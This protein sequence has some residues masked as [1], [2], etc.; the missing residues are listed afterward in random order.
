M[1]TLQRANLPVFAV[2][3]AATIVLLFPVYWMA[4]T[5]VLP[6]SIVLSREPPL[7]PPIDRMTLSAYAEVLGRRPVFQWMLNSLMVAAGSVAI[8]LVASTLAGYS[9][10]RNRSRAQE[11]VGLV[12]LLTKMLPGS[13]I[14]IPFFIMFTTFH[15]I[16]HPLSL[17]LANA[18]AGVPFATW[19][20]KGFFDGIPREIEYAA[21]VD[22]C[23]ELQ[24]LW[25]VVLPLARPG[26]A[27]CAIYL[28]IVTWADFVYARTLVTQPENW[29]LTV[30]LLSFVGE[31]L[32]DWPN[33]MAAGTLSLIPVFILF[34]ILEPYLVSGMTSGSLAN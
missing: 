14:V 3:L 17:M 29:L 32:V 7:L 24:T 5:S 31:Y 2:A 19:L 12:L 28:A 6:T 27:A 26:I 15:L 10:S 20:M 4:V 18:A 23:S 9:L 25:H 8:S 11:A 33:L 30:G 34:L 16:D 1:T 22:G 13:L 21:A